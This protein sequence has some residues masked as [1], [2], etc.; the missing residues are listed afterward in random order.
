MVG[1]AAMVTLS[2]TNVIQVTGLVS[3]RLVEAA[4]IGLTNSCDLVDNLDSATQPLPTQVQRLQRLSIAAIVSF[5]GKRT[6]VSLL[7]A[8]GICAVSGFCVTFRTSSSCSRGVEVAE[9]F[10]QYSSP[11]TLATLENP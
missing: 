3:I 6:L 5:S 10:Q 2:Q 8:Q 9:L 1:P 11:A 4:V 7:R